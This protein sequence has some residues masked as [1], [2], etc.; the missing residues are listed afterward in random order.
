MA[1]GKRVMPKVVDVPYVELTLTKD[2]AEV[3]RC[4][5]DSVGGN[6]HTS[7]RKYTDK[8]SKVL[9][10][11]GVKRCSRLTDK[12]GYCNKDYIAGSITLVDDVD[13]EAQA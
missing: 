7:S 3:L 13:E 10:E 8:I 2:E 12:N 4:V 6:P 11:M 1:T 5:L 9:I